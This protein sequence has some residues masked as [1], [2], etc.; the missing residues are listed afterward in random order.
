MNDFAT[1]KNSEDRTS[2]HVPETGPTVVSLNQQPSQSNTH[3]TAKT[4][5]QTSN[6][7]GILSNMRGEFSPNDHSGFGDAFISREPT[8]THADQ[9][10]HGAF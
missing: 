1:A 7:T 9:R 2:M 8:A 10:S 4:R 6:V 5:P 3:T